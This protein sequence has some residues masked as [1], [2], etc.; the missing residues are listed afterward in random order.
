[1]TAS[2]LSAPWRTDTIRYLHNRNNTTNSEMEGLGGNVPSNQC[3]NFLSASAFGAHHNSLSSG[4]AYSVGDRT[5]SVISESAK[6]CSPCPAPTSPPNPAIS[7]GY[8]FGSS[9]YSCRNVGI[10]QTGLKSGAHAS[11]AGYP[12]DKYMDVSGLTNTPVPTDE[13]SSRAKEFAFYQSYPNPYQRV[14]GY[15]DV[16][17]VPTISGH[18]EPRHE[19]LISMEGYQPW[20]FANGWNGQ[21]YCPKEQTQTPHFWKSPLSGDVMHNQTDINIYRR[22]RKK[23]VPYTKTQLKELEREYATNKFITKEKRR[24]ISTATNLTERQVTIWFQN[25]RV[26]EK[27]VVSKVKENIP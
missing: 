8:H 5:H 27:K 21:V 22:G 26:K 7:Y 11:L 23:R 3:R 25:R 9:Y 18:G 1:M 13:V 10:Q 2:F 12:V 15:L 16:P 14:S 17:V 19:A 4:P 24:R 6:Q 20:S